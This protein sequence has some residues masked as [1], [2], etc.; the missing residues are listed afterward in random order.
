MDMKT[1]ILVNNLG[2]PDDT[3]TISVRRYLRE[4]LGDGR[5]VDVNAILRYILV[6]LIIAPIR[7]FK[8][9]ALYKDVWTENGSLL[10]YHLNELVKKLQDRDVEDVDVYGGMRYQNP[11]LPHVLAKI[12]PS[13]NSNDYWVDAVKEII[14]KNRLYK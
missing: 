2:T 7:G 5:V 8:S 14:D 10:K 1:A 3:R 4:F 9:A 6:N 11:S 12:D 13:L